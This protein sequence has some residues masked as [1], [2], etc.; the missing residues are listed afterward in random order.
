MSK[1]GSVTK[2][3]S[4][5]SAQ[6][7]LK[8]FEETVT[9]QGYLQKGSSGMVKR[10]QNRYFELAGT[11]FKIF[12]A[13]FPRT[14]STCKGV[15]NLDG[16]KSC[17]LDEGVIT[18]E[19]SDGR[20]MKLKPRTEDKSEEWKRAIDSAL[21]LSGSVSAKPKATSAAPEA[22]KPAEMEKKV[23]KQLR[24]KSM[25]Q[26]ETEVQKEETAR[27]AGVGEGGEGEE[28]TEKEDAE[29]TV[30]ALPGDDVPMGRERANSQ[31]VRHVSSSQS[32]DR[33]MSAVLRS[34]KT[35]KANKRADIFSEGLS[36]TATD[37]YKKVVHPK[38]DAG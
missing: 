28:G 1:R 22:A 11:Y 21:G 34:K 20:E 30:S 16:L 9:M 17:E 8:A 32:V 15:I 2:A 5:G 33:R 14:R 38:T 36:V 10:W 3:G 31:S 24:R 25:A 19:L 29:D 7:F 35:G 6:E 26:T 23:E 27:L 12:E 4:E 37:N 18:I 13:A